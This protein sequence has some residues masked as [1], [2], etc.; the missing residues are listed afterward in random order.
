MKRILIFGAI[1]G[2][3]LTGCGANETTNTS[4]DVSTNE[5]SSTVSDSANEETEVIADNLDVP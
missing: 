4:T 2:I 1:A 5:T 3:F